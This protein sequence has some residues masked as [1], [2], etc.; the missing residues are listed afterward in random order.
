MTIGERIRSARIGA[1]MSQRD[2]AGE[3]GL[4]AMAISKYENGEVIPRSG[5]LIQMSEILGVNIDYF[6]RSISVNLSQPQYRCRKPLKKKEANQVHA[7][8]QE[9]LERHLEIELILGEEKSLTLP[10]KETCRIASLD[11]IEDVARRVRDEWSLGL[12][13]IENVM[14]VLEQ[15]GIRV[16]VIDAP[17]TFDALT[18]YY[19]DNTP[20]IA[21]NNDTPGDRQRFNL[22]HELGHLL[23][24]VEGGVDE[25]AAAHRFA[26]AF[27]VPK[28]MAFRELGQ[29]RRNI[30]PREFYLLKHKWG[31]S[32][33]VWLHRAAELGIIS[34]STAERLWTLFNQNKWRER[35]PGVPLPQEHPT[36]MKLLVLRALSE[37]KISTS[38]AQEL[39][40]GEQPGEQCVESF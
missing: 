15:H 35:E 13:P 17:D 22:A 28:E 29:R 10:S 32:M 18:F 1:G 40:G 23:L 34:K 9:W 7:K 11:G 21:V 6:F 26:A 4:S 14:D 2:L 19:D 3:M 24:Q 5:L 12:D 20:V 25:E 8:V 38:R 36:H 16:G 31:M 27:L 39:L 37:K 33:S 30:S